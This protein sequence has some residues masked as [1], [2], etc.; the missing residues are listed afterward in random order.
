MSDKQAVQNRG[1]ATRLG[2][3]IAAIACAVALLVVLFLLF[4]DELDALTAPPGQELSIERVRLPASNRIELTVVN[5]G[6]SPVTIAQVRIDDAYWD[7]SVEPSRTVPRLG[8]ATV[9]IPYP[10]VYG[11]EHHLSLISELGVTFDK[12]IEVAVESPE[13]SPA[14][15][16]RFTLVGLYVGVVPVLLGVMLFPVLRR[17]GSRG[18]DFLLSLTVGLLVFLAIDTWLDAAEFARELPSF[19]QGIPMTVF[20]ALLTVAVLLGISSARAGKRGSPL[21]TAYFIA[22]GIGFHNLGEGLAIGSAY[23]LGQ[24]ALGRFL[25]LGFAVH[26]ITEGIGIAAPVLERAPKLRHFIALILIAGAPAIFGTWLGAYA[27]DPV[28]ATLFLAIGLGA[29]L[30]VIWSVASLL[31]SRAKSRSAALTQPANLAGVFAGIAIMYAT[32]LL[33]QL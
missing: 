31:A 32:G 20:V 7:H 17:F 19:W 15:F 12:T 1:R 16:G 28:L 23:A 22:I 29:I 8:R 3:V 2:V 26:N 18:I 6:P 4:G 33:V 11:E 5:D 30:E 13:F 14:L 24:A 10:W 9:K 27:F 25:I 21:I